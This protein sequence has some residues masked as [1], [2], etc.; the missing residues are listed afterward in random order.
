MA[1]E[2]ESHSLSKQLIC[3]AFLTP[4]TQRCP[5]SYP[6]THSGAYVNP[7]VGCF[8]PR[9]RIIAVDQ[10]RRQGG[11]SLP[12][13][14]IFPTAWG[15]IPDRVVVCGAYPSAK[16]YGLRVVRLFASFS[17]SGNSSY[18]PA[19][20]TVSG[21]VDRV[22]VVKAYHLVDERIHAGLPPGGYGGDLRF[23]PRRRGWSP[24]LDGGPVSKS[25]Q[26]LGVKWFNKC[27]AENPVVCKQK[28]THGTKR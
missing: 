1:G 4:P 6:H 14:N 2:R 5:D 27:N 26:F 9:R 22:P 13:H 23:H 21:L 10:T 8:M 16:P 28:G 19:S 12:Q 7:F 20:A 24:P 17:S 11:A 15:A 25:R 3:L 18:R